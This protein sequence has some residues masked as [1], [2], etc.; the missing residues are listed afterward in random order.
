MKK[1]AFWNWH[2]GA[3]KIVD[4]FDRGEMSEKT[5]YT[6]LLLFVA[7]HVILLEVV[8]FLAGE[9]AEEYG[10]ID[11]LLALVSVG[12]TI[13][14]TMYLYRRHT[15]DTSFIEKYVV[16]IIATIFTVVFVIVIPLSLGLWVLASLAN[17]ELT[18]AMS[19]FDV[20]VLAVT[21]MATYWKLGTY[22]K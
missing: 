21:M 12:L 6:F 20:L 15:A 17:V 18:D 19:W 8:P 5:K 9:F 13:L 7:L 4:Q 22:F 16:T 10:T 1:L 11:K 14:G 3:D 2:L